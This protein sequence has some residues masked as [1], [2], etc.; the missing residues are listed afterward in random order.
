MEAISAA[1]QAPPPHTHRHPRTSRQKIK[2]RSFCKRILDAEILEDEKHI[3]LNCENNGQ[4]AAWETAKS[5]W[6]KTTTRPWPTVSIGLI[7]GATAL[8]FDNDYNRDSE[9]LRILV[10]MT[11]WAIWKSRNKNAIN[12]QN[13]SPNETKEVLKDLISSLIRNSW[14][15]T[16]FMVDK[17]KLTRQRQLRILWGDKRF[18]DFDADPYPT[19]DFS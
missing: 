3:W 9:R 16:R 4:E 2:R 14:I 18:A 17:K 11:T 5:S 7:K 6:Q 10:L 19:V 8:V 15:E 13:V 12:N 1:N